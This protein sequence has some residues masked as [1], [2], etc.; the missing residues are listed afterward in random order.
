MVKHSLPPS[1]AV[2][3]VNY[4]QHQDT[5]ECI[6]SVRQSVFQPVHIVLVDNG[7]K[8]ESPAKLEEAFP[9]L[10]VV[11]IVDNIKCAGGNNRGIEVALESDATHILI[12]NND[13]IIDPSAIG[14]LVNA[15]LDVAVPKIVYYDEPTIIWSAGAH[16]R[17]FPPNILMTGL[18]R[19]DAPKYNVPRPLD[20]ATGCAFL[21]KREVFETIGLFDF[22]YGNYFEDYDF[23]YRLRAA[24]FQAGYVPGA[25]VLHKVSR[26]LGKHP[27]SQ[28]FY[29]ARNTVFFFRRN[30]R[31]PAWM[32]WSHMAYVLLREAVKGKFSHLPDYWG[33][34]GE[35]L[36][37]LKQEV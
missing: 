36:R 28:R 19:P 21:A 26:T 18:Q 8:P 11:R 17:R 23:F 1:V 24:N 15:D 29:S 2:I 35:G 33:G 30:D 27:P 3:L 34:Y 16:W 4:D 7:S 37:L 6:H 14:E 10:P 12:L 25:R 22:S 32:L 5:I 9:D 31:F 20:Y 13:T